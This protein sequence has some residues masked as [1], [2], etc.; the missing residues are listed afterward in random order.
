MLYINWSS[1]KYSGKSN[2]F[3]VC[4]LKEAERMLQADDDTVHLPFE[5][6]SLLQIPVKAL[7]YRWD[8]TVSYKMY[9]VST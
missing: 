5:G 8:K 2:F 9:F 7:K 1:W 4:A 3:C 6:G